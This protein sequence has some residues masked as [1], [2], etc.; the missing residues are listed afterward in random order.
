MVAQVLSP[1]PDSVQGQDQRQLIADNSE[2]ANY[3]R[4]GLSTD[5]SWITWNRHN[6]VWL[7]PDYQPSSMSA[8]WGLAQRNLA[9]PQVSSTDTVMALGNDSGRVTVI[10]IPGSGPYPLL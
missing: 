8:T 3:V 5:K 2:K 9:S 4:Y 7:P 1:D 6:I 10:R